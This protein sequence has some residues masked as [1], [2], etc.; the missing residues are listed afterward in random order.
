VSAAHALPMARCRGCGLEYRPGRGCPK[1]RNARR[2]PR[3]RDERAR[4]GMFRC[5]KCRE[6]KFLAEFDPLP[7]GGRR[8]VCKR[9]V[10]ARDDAQRRA[11]ADQ[12]AAAL[13]EAARL[14]EELARLAPTDAPP[15][16][17]EKF[18]V[19]CD[20]AARRVPLFHPRDYQWPGRWN[21]VVAYVR[22]MT[23]LTEAVA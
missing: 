16:S 11:E 9:C 15:G 4:P 3:P 1:C 22:A 7:T 18:A 14:A 8:T 12:L 2:P 21:A 13:A 5:H 20:R 17:P 10:K 6:R 23:P 19:L